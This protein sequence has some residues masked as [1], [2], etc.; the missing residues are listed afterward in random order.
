[1][2]SR[3]LL[4]LFISFF[5][6]VQTGKSQG[7]NNDYKIDHTDVSQA[8]ELMGLE[9]YKFPFKSN[10]ENTYANVIIEHYI[11]GELITTDNFYQ[12]VKPL[13]EMLDEPLES[14]IQKLDTEEK[15]IRFYIHKKDT[16]FVLYTLNGKTKKPAPFSLKGFQKTGSRAFDDV[17]ASLSDKRRV[18][19]FYANRDSNLIECPGDATPEEIVSLYDMA[20]IVYV[21]HLQIE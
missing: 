15:W 21:E 8:F 18:L 10:E 9:I 6:L 13:L 7:L 11:D 19:T 12:A 17:P 4:F 20:I 3:I 16:S 14:Q 1:M 5:A 2:S